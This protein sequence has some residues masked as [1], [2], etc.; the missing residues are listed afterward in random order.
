MTAQKSTLI[1]NDKSKNS[2]VKF[3]AVICADCFKENK[4]NSLI[5]T[6]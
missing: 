1:L 6:K 2:F 3:L 4:L 5:F